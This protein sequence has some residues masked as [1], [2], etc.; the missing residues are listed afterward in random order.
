MIKREV[1]TLDPATWEYYVANSNF[2]NFLNF[3]TQILIP[4][5]ELQ[6]THRIYTVYWW[7]YYRYSRTMDIKVWAILRFLVAAH[8]YY[9]KDEKE[10]K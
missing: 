1:V 10:Q 5:N 8:T 3:Y 2:N 9:K 4:L 6:I 7:I